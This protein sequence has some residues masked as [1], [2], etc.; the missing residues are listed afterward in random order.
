[1]AAPAAAGA[2]AIAAAGAAAVLSDEQAA[3]QDLEEVCISFAKLILQLQLG[4]K[5]GCTACRWR[6]LVKFKPPAAAGCKG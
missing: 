1:M 5:A 4:A 6:N 3:E 2:A